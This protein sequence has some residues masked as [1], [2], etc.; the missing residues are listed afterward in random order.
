MIRLRDTDVWYLSEIHSSEARFQYAFQIN[1][2][3][4]IPIEYAAMMKMFGENPPRS[5]PLNPRN[6]AGWSYAELPDAPSQ[7]WFNRRTDVP[8]YVT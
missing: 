5:D 7:P 2:P 1:G 4:T 8:A 3:E 6:Y